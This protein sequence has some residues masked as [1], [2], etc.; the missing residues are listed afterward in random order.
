MIVNCLSI[1]F[2]CSVS[3][4][5]TLDIDVDFE[6]QFKVSNSK[7]VLDECENRTTQKFILFIGLLLSVLF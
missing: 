1:N 2:F 4:F 6:I 5:S 3:T 7:V